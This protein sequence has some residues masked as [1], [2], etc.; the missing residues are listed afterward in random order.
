[1]SE[2]K[3]TFFK[4]T[5]FNCYHESPWTSLHK[6]NPYNSWLLDSKLEI[7]QWTVWCK[8][9]LR[10]PK[11]N[12][13]WLQSTE[14]YILT[15]LPKR[16]TATSE[17]KILQKIIFSTKICKCLNIGK[18]DS[19]CSMRN[20]QYLSKSSNPWKARYWLF[21]MYF[22]QWYSFTRD[23]DVVGNFFLMTW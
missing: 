11:R 9:V 16:E 5:L 12:E 15:I 6:V 17:W 8:Q 19:K 4:Q 18:E 1:M 22:V 7:K 3:Q 2:N 14:A 21:D 10:L 23:F 20:M 13:D